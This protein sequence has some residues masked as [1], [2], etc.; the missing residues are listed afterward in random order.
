M[1]RLTRFFRKVLGWRTDESAEHL[2]HVI[3]GQEPYS[4]RIKFATQETLDKQD[5]IRFVDD[6]EGRP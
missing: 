6:G 2:P 4:T 3:R 1:D 5:V